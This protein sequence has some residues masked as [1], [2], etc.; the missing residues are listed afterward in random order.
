MQ[1]PG[2]EIHHNTIDLTL[3]SEVV[4]FI[5]QQVTFEDARMC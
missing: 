4:G 1:M 2:S 3:I 5:V